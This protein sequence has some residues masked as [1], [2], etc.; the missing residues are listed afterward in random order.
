MLTLIKI[1]FAYSYELDIW[2]IYNS[3]KNL[4][5]SIDSMILDTESQW[6]LRTNIVS[7]MVLRARQ[8]ILI[9]R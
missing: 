2:L 9:L 1:A 4:G 3:A 7:K 8:F 5:C 6:S